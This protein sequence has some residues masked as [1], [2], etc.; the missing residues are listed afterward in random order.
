MWLALRRGHLLHSLALGMGLSKE[1]ASSGSLSGTATSGEYIHIA[2]PTAATSPPADNTALRKVREHVG[3]VT[4][5][6]FSMHVDPSVSLPISHSLPSQY[7]D[8]ANSPFEMH[9]CT[10]L[11]RMLQVPEG[12]AKRS[13]VVAVVSTP[14]K[15]WVKYKVVNM[16][17]GLVPP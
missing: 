6:G 9:R 17:M 5:V 7:K 10:Q 1:V 12:L 15:R 16:H 3:I 14:S 11:I 13:A 4:W 8:C 2:A